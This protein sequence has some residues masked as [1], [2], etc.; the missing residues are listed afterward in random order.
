MST[1]LKIYSVVSEDN[2]ETNEHKVIFTQIGDTL[3]NSDLIDDIISFSY[4]EWYLESECG[5]TS[6]LVGDDLIDLLNKHLKSDECDEKEE[7]EKI[8]PKLSEYN[9]D[10][11]RITISY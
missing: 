8:L 3:H 9:E 2:F 11:Y 4:R 6:E 1:D 10:F 5:F 7:I